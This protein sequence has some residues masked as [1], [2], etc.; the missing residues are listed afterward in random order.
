M[1]PHAP[2]RLRCVAQSGTTHNSEPTERLRFGSSQ[3]RG[4][5]ER[6]S[7]SYHCLMIRASVVLAAAL[8][9]GASLAGC[10][11]APKSTASTS[12]VPATSAVPATPGSS[13]APGASTNPVVKVTSVTAIKQPKSPGT[14]KKTTPAE[15]VTFT[16]SPVVR[17]LSCNVGAAS[18]GR[19]SWV[20]RN[21]GRDTDQLLS[22]RYCVSGRR[23]GAGGYLRR[24]P[25]GRP[26]GVSRHLSQL[27]PKARTAGANQSMRLDLGP[28]RPPPFVVAQFR[29]TGEEVVTRDYPGAD[30]EEIGDPRRGDEADQLLGVGH[31]AA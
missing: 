14:A 3:L 22:I 26:S 12:S 5:K 1:N 16:V 19:S 6:G 13:R 25:L 28:I 27:Q 20:C 18:F 24:H 10:S 17:L 2:T 8:C 30:E 4:T 21:Q 31:S 29:S 7:L 15:R 23:R 9:V 11:T